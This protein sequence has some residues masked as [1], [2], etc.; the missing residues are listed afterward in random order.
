MYKTNIY[1]YK[2]FLNL[3]QDFN[4]RI[5]LI[6]HLILTNKKNDLKNYL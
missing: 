1:E 2:D 6:F 5:Y 3:K 4:L